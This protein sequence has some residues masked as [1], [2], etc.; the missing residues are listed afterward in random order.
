MIDATPLLKVY[1]RY[2]LSALARQDQAAAQERVLMRLLR[3]AKRTRFGRDHGFESIRTVAEYQRRVPLRTYQDFWREYWGSDFPRLQGCTWPGLIRYFA[4]TSGT[5]S[6]VRKHI[7]VS[8]EMLSSNTRAAFDLFVHHLARHRSSRLLAGKNFMLGGSTALIEAAPGIYH[9]DLSGIMVSEVPRWARR[10]AFPPAELGREHDW[11]KKTTRLA[12]L[13]LGEHIRS[14]GGT[15]SWVLL[16]IDKLLALRLD[17]RT[18]ADLYPHLELLVHG[19]VDFRPYRAIFESL[20][21]G[22]SAELR[23]VYPASE[24]FIAIADRG[25]GEG[26]R[27]LV[28]NGLFFEFVPAEELDTARPRRHWLGDVETGVSYAIVLTTCAGLWSYVLGDTVRFIDTR[29]G[30]LLV[31]GRTSQFLSAFGEH[32]SGEHVANAVAEVAAAIGT[33]IADYTVGPLFPTH[34]GE[35]G[36]HLFIIEFMPPLDDAVRLARF[37]EVLD[38]SLKRANHEYEEY[39]RHDHQIAPPRVQPAPPGTFARWMERQ[40]KSGGQHKVPRIIR[41]PDQ[42]VGLLSFIEG[43]R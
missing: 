5:T 1:A 27:L 38:Q 39:R 10:F 19:G 30:R 9:G 17:A 23:E 28:D 43:R 13:S 25:F 33:G 36:R 7:P 8:R 16:F 15:P 3:R 35:R 2:R 6:G 32:L 40:G 42:L 34:E 41:D 18:V 24:G 29:P 21:E 4:D 31:T 37:T 22:S 26:L 11:E 12:E 14:F 20:L